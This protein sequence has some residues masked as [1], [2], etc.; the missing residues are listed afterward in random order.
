MSK[1]AISG[2]STGTATFTIESPATSTNRTLTLP[3]ETGTI[4]T[5]GIT[6]G[7]SASAISTG[8]LAAARLPAGSVLQV[9]Q[10]FKNDTTSAT[11]AA[12]ID[13]WV[14][15]SGMSVTITPTSAS[16]KI[17]VLLTLN[18]GGVQGQAVAIQILRGATAIGNG[19]AS[20]SRLPCFA[21]IRQTD[22][23]E[24]ELYSGQYLDS[25]NTT[26]S[27]TYKIQWRKPYDFA[28]GGSVIYLNR[29]SN[30][31]DSDDRPRCSSS[32]TVM[33]IAG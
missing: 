10:T 12:S 3:D 17:L 20:G 7:L 4:V 14:D 30:D 32:I 11:N 23:F 21:D 18:I 13:T 6:T 22:Q 29:S 15:I 8:T 2:A 9:L 1:I 24:C 33:E 5:T 25:P 16:N 19:A 31:G 27:T 26:S 28:G